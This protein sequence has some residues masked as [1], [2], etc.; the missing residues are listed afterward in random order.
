[1]EYLLIKKITLA[2]FLA[3]ITLH[4]INIG[5]SLKICKNTSIQYYWIVLLNQRKEKFFFL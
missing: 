5:I 1:M 2:G 3:L 4:M